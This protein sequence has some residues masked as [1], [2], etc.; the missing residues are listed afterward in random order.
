MKAAG[1]YWRIKQPENV[2]LTVTSVRCKSESGAA[3]K[4]KQLTAV[5]SMGTAT[6]SHFSFTSYLPKTQYLQII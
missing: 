3:L 6:D 2:L 1:L 5:E 4:C